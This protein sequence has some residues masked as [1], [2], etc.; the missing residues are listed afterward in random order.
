[1]SHLLSEENGVFVNLSSSTCIH[2]LGGSVA[3]YATHFLN[4]VAKMCLERK[5]RML[6]FELFSICTREKAN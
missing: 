2:T 1:M 3:F 6:L 4:G 5:R